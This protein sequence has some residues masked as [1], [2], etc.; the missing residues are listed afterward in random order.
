MDLD[1]RDARPQD[2]ADWLKLWNDYLAFY[3]VDLAED[4]TAH[5]WARIMDPASR[6]SARLA[7]LD[8]QVVGFA[9][10]HSHDSTWVRH[11]I[12]I[13]KTSSSMPPFAAKALVAR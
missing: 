9:I 7:V 10:H 5:T 13:W 3:N 11:R 1:I 12:A 6:V 4:V 2:H 8:G